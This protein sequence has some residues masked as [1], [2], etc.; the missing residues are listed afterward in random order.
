M[1]GGICMVPKYHTRG[2][3]LIAKGKTNL[4]SLGRSSSHRLIQM[5]EVGMVIV[6]CA[7]IPCLLLGYDLEYTIS[8]LSSIFAQTSNCVSNQASILNLKYIGSIENG[9]TGEMK[10]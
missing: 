9:S 2:S 6:E 4:S 8:N 1:I 7:D 5:I 10:P 3:L